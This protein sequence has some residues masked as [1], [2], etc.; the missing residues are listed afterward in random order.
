VRPDEIRFVLGSQGPWMTTPHTVFEIVIENRGI[1][2]V[3]RV[4]IIWIPVRRPI[5][6]TVFCHFPQPPPPIKCPRYYLTKFMKAYFI[7][8]K[9][10]LAFST[11]RD[12][13]QKISGLA[14]WRENCKWYNCLP[15]GAVV[16]LFC[17]SV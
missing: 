13:I 15:L 10:G 1:W 2:S 4:R 5:A 8:F 9:V 7:S 17:E 3:L 14:A 16:S 6:L 12:C 11:I